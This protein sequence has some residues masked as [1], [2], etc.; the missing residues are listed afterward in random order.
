MDNSNSRPP[1]GP[2]R[3]VRHGISGPVFVGAFFAVLAI[4]LT[5]FGLWRESNLSLRN[6]VL[7]AALGGGTWGLISWAIAT[8]VAQ[9]EDD[10]AADDSHADDPSSLKH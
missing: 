1:T 5:L 4:V 3:N 8:A 6:I 2:G 10:I 7:G 9:V